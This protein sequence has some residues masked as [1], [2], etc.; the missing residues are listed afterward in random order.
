[1]VALRK[2]SAHSRMSTPLL[3]SKPVWQLAIKQLQSSFSAKVNDPEGIPEKSSARAKH[4]PE[5]KE[6]CESLQASSLCPPCSSA[7]MDEADA[8][9]IKTKASRKRPT[10]SQKG[11]QR[12]A[13]RPQ[14]QVHARLR[15]HSAADQDKRRDAPAKQWACSQVLLLD[16]L[17]SSQNKDVFARPQ[18]TDCEPRHMEKTDKFTSNAQ[19]RIM[20][21]P[22]GAMLATVIRPSPSS[23]KQT[24]CWYHPGSLLSRSC[25]KRNKHAFGPSPLHRPL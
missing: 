20:A 1:M 8:R 17:T 14:K 21:K 5:S 25:R 12:S 4:A 6:V 3:L 22:W 9:M 11:L 19:K 15:E 18:P 10:W 23:C 13:S 2:A 7:L 16:V 24:P